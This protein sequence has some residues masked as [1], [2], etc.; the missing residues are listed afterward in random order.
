MTIHR[1]HPIQ[2]E[3]NGKT[4]DD[5]DSL[6]YDDCPRCAEHAEYIITMDP[7]KLR[8]MWQTMIDVEYEGLA[9]HYGTRTEADACRKLY[10]IS[11]INSKLFNVEAQEMIA[12]IRP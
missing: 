11:V 2:G 8:L 4:F 1:P 5:K 10:A 3:W 9:D 6:L 12:K 7:Q